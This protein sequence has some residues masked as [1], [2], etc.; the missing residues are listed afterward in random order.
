VSASDLAAALRTFSQELLAGMAPPLAAAIAHAAA[1][2]ATASASAAAAGHAGAAPAEPLPPPLQLG[3][4][5]AV[6]RVR[7]HRARRGRD[8][9]MEVSARVAESK[10]SARPHTPAAAA[11]VVPT[12]PPLPT[13]A[14][15]PATPVRGGGAHTPA[16]GASIGSAGHTPAA[17]GASICSAAGTRPSSVLRPP[18][19]ARASAARVSHRPPW[20]SPSP[21]AA[22]P[23]VARPL[24]TTT[25]ADPSP[26]SLAVLL[27]DEARAEPGG[28]VHGGGGTKQAA[29]G[30]SL[31]A[32]HTEWGRLSDLV[33]QLGDALEEDAL[34]TAGIGR[35]VAALERL[36][37][38]SGAAH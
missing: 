21:S 24:T 18:A 12:A 16:R 6:T 31:A 19:A 3:A 7:I 11:E 33:A 29:G 32:G 2:A 30:G 1:A 25:S 22:R 27:A 17:R 10:G 15:V 4:R 26:S 28:V 36:L 34:A 8:G 20:R 14:G 23:R 37:H 35:G 9:G 38:T 5:T 13:A